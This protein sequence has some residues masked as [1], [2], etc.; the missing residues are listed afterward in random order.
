M[1]I[2]ASM[3]LAGCTSTSPMESDLTSIPEGFTDPKDPNQEL[4]MKNELEDWALF[5]P[6]IVVEKMSEEDISNIT[7]VGGSIGI[8]EVDVTNGNIYVNSDISSFGD[9]KTMFTVP[10]IHFSA[11]NWSNF[12]A[13]FE[14]AGA[15]KVYVWDSLFHWTGHMPNRYALGA[16]GAW[17][18]TIINSAING[19][20][21]M[22]VI[23]ATEG[24]QTQYLFVSR[25]GPVGGTT[26]PWGVFLAENGAPITGYPTGMKNGVFTE[27]E[28][29]R[30]LSQMFARGYTPISLEQLPSAVKNNWAGRNP[31]P[32]YRYVWWSLA[33][34]LELLA[35]MA[36]ISI[37][38]AA[39]TLSTWVST[40][41][42]DFLPMFILVPNCEEESE[43]PYF[44]FW[45]G[46]EERKL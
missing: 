37:S 8:G 30:F 10:L 29:N 32:I 7:N 25:I 42:T 17:I 35:R 1:I 2:F 36:S 24:T 33:Y 12:Y 3:I 26:Q 16:N 46:P 44:F 14:Y 11:S 38:E 21:A 4:V 6:Q 15:T 23:Q 5:S 31:P 22:Y 18:H 40:S 39:I 34:Q 19:K 28:A 27:K 20:G 41:T 45:C 43:D 9:G 13:P